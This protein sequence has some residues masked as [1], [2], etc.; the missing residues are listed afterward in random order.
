MFM[1]LKNGVLVYQEY[2]VGVKSHSTALQ[3]PEIKRVY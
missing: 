2:V 3:N 1:N